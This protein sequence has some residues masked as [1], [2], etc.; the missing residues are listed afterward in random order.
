M[1]H[2]NF[3]HVHQTQDTHRKH[4]FGRTM[5]PPSLIDPVLEST[6]EIPEDFGKCNLILMFFFNFENEWRQEK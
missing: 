4:I 6:T 1:I 5:Y 3:L 2:T